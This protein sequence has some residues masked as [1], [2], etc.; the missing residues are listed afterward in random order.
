MA[1]KLKALFIKGFFYGQKYI[2]NIM[3]KR[4]ACKHNLQAVTLGKEVYFIMS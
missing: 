2:K 3:S 4:K 1:C